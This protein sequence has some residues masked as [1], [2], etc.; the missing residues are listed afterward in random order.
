M[1]SICLRVEL[2]KVPQNQIDRVSFIL[3]LRAACSCSS[4]A[5]RT[6][7]AENE[8][9]PW[10]FCGQ[11]FSLSAAAFRMVP[12][13]PGLVL[14]LTELCFR[15]RHFGHLKSVSGSWS[16][17]CNTFCSTSI[18]IV[19]G[20]ILSKCISLVFWLIRLRRA[21]EL[22]PPH[23][24]LLQLVRHLGQRWVGVFHESVKR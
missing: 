1:A 20:E 3:V 7:M 14:E 17:R 12:F 23:L 24:P 19:S 18:L 8:S 16:C 6:S 11:C 2:C 22:A 9:S 5:L 15:L 10:V 13:P 21:Q 4:G